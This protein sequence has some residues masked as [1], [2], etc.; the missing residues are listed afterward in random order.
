MIADAQTNYVYFSELL[1]INEKYR[2]FSLELTALLD[3]YDIRYGFLENT[4]DI[5]CRDYMPVQVDNGQFVEYRY[6]PDYLQAVKYRH[7]KTYP[8]MVCEAMGL[9][10]T[11]TNIILD[12]GNVIRSEN[13]VILTDKIFKENK[14]IYSKNELL[15]EL[16]RLF[17]VKDVIIIPWDK[18]SEE[19]GHADGMIRFIDEDHVLINAYFREY[20]SSFQDKLYGVLDEAG[21]HLTEINFNVDKPDE[22][23]NW[24]YVNFLQLGDLIIVPKIGIAEDSQ[25]LEQIRTAFPVYASMNRVVDIDVTPILEDGGALNCISWNIIS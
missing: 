14:A 15:A 25:A 12:G 1:R 5:W 23:F 24:A 18:E 3:T 6:D 7:L 20:S 2:A 21:I 9:K 22:E 8:D 19:Y 11:K 10:T 13:R 17:K 4:Q 16:R